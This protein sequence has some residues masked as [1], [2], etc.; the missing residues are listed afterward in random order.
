MGVEDH[1]LIAA[2]RTGDR[3]AFAV[4]IDRET[5]MVYRTCLRI[6]GRVEDAED[7]TQ[8]TFVAAFR[9]L[10]TF[11][12]E[13]SARGWLMRIAQ[14]QAF[15]RLSQ[16]RPTA[17]LAELDEARLADSTTEPGRAVVAAE[18]RDEVRRAVADLPEPYR[19]TVSLRFFADLS[20]AEVA[21]ATG[22]PLATVK[23]H[24]RRGL[25]RLRPMMRV[26]GDR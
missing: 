13:G 21:E 18:A 19:E 6:L 7:V 16:R 17:A 4:L 11:R 24:L 12:G 26:G 3:D 2:L 5:A 15:R 25:E 22:R 1:A 8:E 10:T 14:R 23:T 20:L 9:S